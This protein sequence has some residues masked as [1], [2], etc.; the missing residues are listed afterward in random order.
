[1]SNCKFREQDG[2]FCDLP[3]AQFGVTINTPAFDRT[4]SIMVCKTHWLQYLGDPEGFIT[5]HEL[6]SMR[7][8][9]KEVEPHAGD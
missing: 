7:W 8:L 2:S 3:D 1:M 6:G 4:Y 9:V 5:A